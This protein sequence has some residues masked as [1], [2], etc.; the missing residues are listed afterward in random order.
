MANGIRRKDA[1]GMQELVSQYIREM[2]I[3]SVSI[4]RGL[5]KHGKRF[6]EHLVILWMS[7]MIKV[8]SIAASVRLSCAIS[9]IFKEMSFFRR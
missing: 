1:V 7:I 9:F 8:C 2:K 6:P 5:Q 3:A 4:G